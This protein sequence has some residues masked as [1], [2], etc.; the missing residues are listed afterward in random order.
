[1]RPIVHPHALKVHMKHQTKGRV[2]HDQS[3]FA[4]AQHMSGLGSSYRER[5]GHSDSTEVLELARRE[6]G[7]LVHTAAVAFL[8]RLPDRAASSVL[9][10]RSNFRPRRW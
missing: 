10:G 8:K 9:K 5:A 2:E 7:K 6:K 4:N 3:F 1:M